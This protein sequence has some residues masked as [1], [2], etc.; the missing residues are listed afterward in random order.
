MKKN[1][2]SLILSENVVAEIDRLAHQLHTNRSSLINRILAE[3]VSYET[4]EL[5]TEKVFD[6]LSGMLG[7]NDEFRI[8]PQPSANVFV[9]STPLAY[10][11][12]PTVRYTVEIFRTQGDAA[13]NLKVSLRTRSDTLEETMQRFF[14]LWSSLDDRCCCTENR[15]SRMIPTRE[16]FEPEEC[17]K[18]LY[19][20]VQTMDKAMKLFFAGNDDDSKTEEQ[21]VRVFGEYTGK[22][23]E[24]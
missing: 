11:Y 12:N 2:Y 17:A 10:K 13:G 18:E 1:T 3:Y 7:G 16:E 23:N 4:P 9:L 21:I 19:E 22:Q 20:Y 24:K 5:K 14:R 15:F 6:L 8:M